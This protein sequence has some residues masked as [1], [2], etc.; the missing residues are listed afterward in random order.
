MT[1]DINDTDTSLQEKDIDYDNIR[2]T[3]YGSCFVSRPKDKD[4]LFFNFSFDEIE[5]VFKRIYY[6]HQTGLE[7]FSTNNKTYYFNFKNATTRN[8]IYDIIKSKINSK[9][10]NIN[11]DNIITKWKKYEISNMELIM[12]LNV[13]GGRSYNDLSQYPVI[14]WVLIN[15]NKEKLQETDL[16]EDKNLYRDLSLPLGMITLN[17]NGERKNSYIFNLK[18]TTIDYEK[19]IN[20]KNENTSEDLYEKPY[21]YGSHYSNPFYVS[22]YLTRIFPFAYIMIELQGDKFDDPDR[23]FINFDNSFICATTQKGDVRELIPEIYCLP[24]IY[25]NI[26]NFDMGIKRDKEKVNDVLC[27]LW[28]QNNPYK[29]ITFLNLAFESDEVSFNINNWIDLIFGYKQRG[30]EAEKANNVYIFNSYPDLVDIENLDEEKKIYYYRFVEFGSCPRQLFT[31]QFQKREKLSNFKQIIDKDINV[32]TIEL[33]SKNSNSENLVQQMIEMH[34]IIKMFPTPKKSAKFLYS[35]FT[36]IELI[37]NKINENTYKYEQNII[38]YG[39]GIKYEKYLLGN[40]RI[41]DN[42]PAAMYNKGKYL[43]EG[44]YIN[45]SMMITDFENMTA[46]ILYNPNDKSP[47]TSIL[48]NKDENMGIVSNNI[49]IIYIYNISGKKWEYINKVHYHSKKINYL[50]ISDELNAFASCSEDNFVNI[51]GLPSCN[52]IHSFEIEEPEL[53][54]LSARP[55][56]VCLIYSKTLK[57]LNIYGVNGNLICGI[58][59]DEKPQYPFIYTSKYYRDYLI[60][61]KKGTVFIHTFPYLEIFNTIKIPGDDSVNRELY[62]EYQQHKNGEELYVLEKDKQILYIIGDQS[63][64]E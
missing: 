41:N 15:N 18:T 13:L 58:D 10:Y 5:Y 12:W 46:E 24:E 20:N 16:K 48:I 22:H 2:H 53:V 3:C 29:L 14:P 8:K 54:L 19:K 7:I 1:N 44:G 42:P 9:K 64:N 59:V 37:Q 21:N 33:K 57:K 25:Y 6:Y 50:F 23:M 62:L 61:S 49:G 36:G 26:N 43:I 38:I 32:I 27:P 17:D 34:K 4:N 60:Y 47:V 55:L 31:K 56:P 51:Y 45:G 11:A 30:K 63:V 40:N 52:L 39:Y 28:T 35:D